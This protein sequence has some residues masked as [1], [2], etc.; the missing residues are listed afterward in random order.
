MARRERITKE[1]VDSLRGAERDAIVWDE[2]LRAFGVRVRPTGGKHYVLRMRVDGR[3]R[4]YT[5]GEHGQPWTPITARDEAKRVM[6]QAATVTKLRATGQAPANLRHPIEA[7]EVGRSTPTLGQFAARYLTEHAIPHKRPETTEADRGLLGLRERAV[8]EGKTKPRTILGALGNMRVDRI[9]RADVVQ[10]HLAWKSTPTRANRAVALLSHM[11]TMSEKWGLRPD[12]SNPCRHIERYAEVRR[13][14]FLSATE[15]GKLGKTLAALDHSETVSP[16][17][18]AAVRL[19]LF[20]GA[21][22]SEVLG[23]TWTLVDLKAGSVRLPQSK[24]GPKTLFLNPPARAILA[25]LPRLKGNPFVVVGG[26]EGRPLTLSGLEQVWQVVRAKAGLEDVRLH[27]LRH[28]FAS[29][30]VAGGASLPMVGALLGHTT[31]ETTKRYAHLA[32][33]PLAAASKS[34]GRAIASAMRAR[35]SAGRGSVGRSARR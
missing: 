23:L 26:R 24:T 35:S 11:F 3:Q 25:K 9:T 19:L 13:E 15:L 2:E 32:G 33:D 8:P 30:A 29:A 10:L 1:L 5:I 17:A 22:A 7:R 16:F 6:G 18:L 21:R 14:R 20:T 27:D 12:A 4:W 31:A 28:S 34:I